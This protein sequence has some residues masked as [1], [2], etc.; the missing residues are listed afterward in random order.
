MPKKMRGGGP[1]SIN[2]I[3]LICLDWKKEKNYIAVVTGQE[4]CSAGLTPYKYTYK[5]NSGSI[6]EFPD[7][8]SA[9][10]NFDAYMK[11]IGMGGKRRKTKGKKRSTKKRRTKKRKLYM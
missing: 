9:K 2:T 8:A 7:Y 11:T 4:T 3:Y 1:P 10:T 6:S 5:N